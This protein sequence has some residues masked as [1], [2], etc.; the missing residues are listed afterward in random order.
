MFLN[1]SINQSLCRFYR[2]FYGGRLPTR[3]G[4]KRGMDDTALRISW[5]DIQNVAAT[6]RTNVNES[7]PLHYRIRASVCSSGKLLTDRT[8]HFVDEIHCSSTLESISVRTMVSIK[9]MSLST[10]P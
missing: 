1:G 5:F 9:Q 4:R 2:L 8:H 10:S 7:P 6:S 3:R